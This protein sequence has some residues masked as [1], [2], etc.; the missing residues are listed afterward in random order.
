MYSKSP[1]ESVYGSIVGRV[2]LIDKH[3]FKNKDILDVGCGLG[4]FLSYSKKLGLKS[5]TGIDVDKTSLKH[6]REYAKDMSNYSFRKGSGT[7]LPF[8]DNTF[9]VAVAWEVVE[10][11]PSNTE[12][13]FFK[14]INRV[15]KPGGH[16]YLS[17]PL[18][19]VASK[20][21]DPAWYILGHRHY[22][23]KQM[24]KFLL[25]SNFSLHRLKTG[26]AWGAIGYNSL[27]YISHWLFKR[28]IPCMNYFKKL[29]SEEYS[30]SSGFVTLLVKC[31]NEN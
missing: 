13:F 23:E 12:I 5:Y 14:E 26:G 15:L 16:L 10:H 28:D 4:W 6:A 25:N 29:A 2:E 1:I 24:I 21:T 20:F 3:D 27:M 11:I 8:T 17:T 31:R 18:N 19:T 9:D 30:R 22:S 7:K